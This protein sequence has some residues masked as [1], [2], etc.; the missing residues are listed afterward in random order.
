MTDFQK[1]S[2]RDNGYRQEIISRMLTVYIQLH[3]ASFGDIISKDFGEILMG[4]M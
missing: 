2:F 3:F 4:A 1:I